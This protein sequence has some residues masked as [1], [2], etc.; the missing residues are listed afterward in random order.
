MRLRVQPCCTADD[1]GTARTGLPSKPQPKDR[2][3]GKGRVRAIRERRVPRR[4]TSLK[5]KGVRLLQLR[6]LS[7]WIDGESGRKCRACQ[8]TPDSQSYC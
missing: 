1:S 8:G 4:G 7:W 6:F 3:D 2:L 5:E